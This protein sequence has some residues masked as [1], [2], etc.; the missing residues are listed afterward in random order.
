ML[1]QFFFGMFFVIA[2]SMKKIILPLLLLPLISIG[3]TFSGQKVGASIGL[4]L[5]IGT[6]VNSVGVS[7]KANYHDFFYQLN[8]GTT[9]TFNLTSYGDRKKFW[10]TRSYLGLILLAGKKQLLPDFQLDGLL[11][12][13]V[14]NYGIG[15]NYCWYYDNA[16]TSQRSAGWGMHLKNLAILFENDVFAGQAKDRFRTGHLAFSYRKQDLKFTSGLYLWTGET[17]N[18]VW[19][20]LSMNY[21]PSGFRILEDLPYG[22][23]SHG[24]IY[25]GISYNIGFGQ[26][27]QM[28]IGIDSEQIRHGFQNRLT[29]DLLFLPKKIERNTPHYPRLDENGCPVF[30]KSLIRKNKFYLQFGANENWSN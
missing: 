19:Q 25:G 18:S 8:A 9:M 16:G 5:N 21:C 1:A 3:Q 13:T 11:H 28:R 15:Y 24:I 7:F 30:E 27:A 22:K 4:L 6:H 14:Y 10:E 20:H 12:N 2:V 26:I 23:S 29:H 17:A